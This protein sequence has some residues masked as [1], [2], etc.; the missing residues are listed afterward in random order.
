MVIRPRVRVRVKV[1][2]HRMEYGGRGER[3]MVVLDLN[4]LR[5]RFLKMDILVQSGVL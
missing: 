1:S 3:E 2:G 4:N 5:P